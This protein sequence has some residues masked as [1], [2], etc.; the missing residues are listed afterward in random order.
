VRIEHRPYTVDA[1]EFPSKNLSSDPHLKQAIDITEGAVL[2]YD[3][4]SRASFDLVARGIQEL[5]R[6]T[7][8]GI[9][10]YGL[11]LVGNK[12][13]CDVEEREVSWA[14]AHRASANF[15][16]RC[17]F[18]ETSAKSGD[19]I[20]RL[21]PELGREILKLRFLMQQRNEHAERLAAAAEEALASPTK[22]APRWRSWT[23]P[24]F[25][26]RLDGRKASVA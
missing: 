26:R 21:F 3:V 17:A 19:N 13:D 15:G 4:K 11:V 2:V 6:D 7:I 16:V 1:L 22:K 9:R 12:S 25:Q 18:M 14:E 10:E 5:I 24:W 8:G 23:R 20:D